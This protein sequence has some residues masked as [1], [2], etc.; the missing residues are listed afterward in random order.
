MLRRDFPPK[1]R[2]LIKKHGDEKIVEIRIYRT[3]V[4]RGLNALID[5]LSA[6]N[7]TRDK[8]KMGFD[9]FFHLFMLFRTDEN[10]VFL[11]EKNQVIALEKMPDTARR[12]PETLN[13][14]RMAGADDA[15]TESFDLTSSVE[16][17]YEPLTIDAFFKNVQKFLSK[18]PDRLY[19]YDLF[20]ANCQVYIHDLVNAN[21]LAFGA[22][23][24]GFNAFTVQDLSEVLT[25]QTALKSLLKIVT[26]AAAA[27]DHL[28]E[29]RGGR[30]VPRLDF[31]SDSDFEYFYK[32]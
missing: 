18:N 8:L 13:L 16:S 19:V 25:D 10:N 32:K 29:G 27:A 6:G 14:N 31:D 1:M 26:D 9:E 5:F 2:E 3:P 4:S 11:T 15:Q 20:N 28:I 30:V 24:D 17:L 22:I 12:L 21:S 23:R 7:L